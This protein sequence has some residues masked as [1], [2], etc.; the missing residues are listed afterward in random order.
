[1]EEQPA[2]RERVRRS[3]AEIAEII[4]TYRQSGQRQREFCLQ[5][6]IGVS[7]LQNYLRRERSN[8][9]PKQR[10]LEVEVAPTSRAGSESKA[11]EVIVANGYRIAVGSGFAA[12]DLLRLVK[13]MERIKA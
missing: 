7:T 1:M 6:G 3:R 2:S 9:Q 10:L 11:L 4:A 12:E 8:G 5:R 13:V